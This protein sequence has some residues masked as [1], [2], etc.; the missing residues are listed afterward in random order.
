M[1][2]LSSEYHTKYIIAYQK[3]IEGIKQLDN[4]LGVLRLY[5]QT[6][7]QKQIVI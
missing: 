4:Y 1:K 2:H 6:I 5:K 7:Y 3:N